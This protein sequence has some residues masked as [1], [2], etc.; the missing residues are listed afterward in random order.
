VEGAARKALQLLDYVG[1]HDPWDPFVWGR[2]Q[3]L[4]PRQVNALPGFLPATIDPGFG[5]KEGDDYWDRKLSEAIHHFPRAA[6]PGPSGLRPSHLQ[7]A[8]KRKGAAAPLLHARPS[9]S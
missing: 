7:D 1:T 5:G 6:A 4:H 2:L 3:E 8:L 9:P